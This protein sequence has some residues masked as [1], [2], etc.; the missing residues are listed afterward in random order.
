MSL[1][2]KVDSHLHEK[3]QEQVRVSTRNLSR[4]DR[5]SSTGASVK[6]DNSIPPLFRPA[7]EPMQ[8]ERG[9]LMLHERLRGN[10][11]GE[12]L[13]FGQPGHFVSVCPVHPKGAAL[14]VLGYPW[15]RRH[16]PHIDSALGK[17]VD[18]HALCLKSALS[19]ADGAD[20][21]SPAETSLLDLS[22]IPT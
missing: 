3:R 6:S 1:A 5:R 13:Y 7:E 15:L 20:S 8:L 11:A 10:R 18:C 2:I 14:L 16:N 9:K 19:P 21:P 22:N 4:S 17:I 12:C